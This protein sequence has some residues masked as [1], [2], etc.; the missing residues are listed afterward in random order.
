MRR[1]AMH[2]LRCSQ[3]GTTECSKDHWRSPECALRARDAHISAPLFRS[4]PSR[5]P[6]SSPSVIAFKSSNFQALHSL[7]SSV[8]LR[9]TRHDLPSAR[10]RGAHQSALQRPRTYVCVHMMPFHGLTSVHRIVIHAAADR[11]GNPLNERCPAGPV[12][13]TP[14]RLEP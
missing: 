11:A 13:V 7:S 9:Q 8:S 1:I 12:A 14:S 5:R 10:R 6:H 2:C 3:K 4:A